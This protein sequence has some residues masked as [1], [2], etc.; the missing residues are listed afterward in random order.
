[1]A[2]FEVSL[3]YTVKVWQR[4]TE[5]HDK[6]LLMHTP[7]LLCAFLKFAKDIPK[8]TEVSLKNTRKNS[9]Q[10]MKCEAKPFHIKSPWT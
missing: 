4:S 1:M 6:D 7:E 3:N 9:V 2:R 8:L 10:I 5:S